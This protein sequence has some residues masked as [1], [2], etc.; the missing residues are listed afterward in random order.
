MAARREVLKPSSIHSKCGC[1]GSVLVPSLSVIES[2]IPLN[3]PWTEIPLHARGFFTSVGLSDDPILCSL[4]DVQ[5]RGVFHDIK[6]T[7]GAEFRCI[8][9]VLSQRTVAPAG[10]AT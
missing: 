7:A 1:E 10:L 6:K 2:E 8:R 5:T 3:G 9:V 4:V